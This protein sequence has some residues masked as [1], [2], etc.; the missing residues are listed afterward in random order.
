MDKTDLTLKAEI[1]LYYDLQVPDD[2]RNA[3]L[4]IAV[5]GYGAH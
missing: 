5:H 1:T 4:L 3:P 2:A